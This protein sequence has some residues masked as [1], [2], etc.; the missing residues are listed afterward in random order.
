M[1][2]LLGGLP[3]LNE[4]GRLHTVAKLRMLVRRENESALQ[5]AFLAEPAQPV[6]AVLMDALLVGTTT[7]RDLALA[8]LSDDREPAAVRAAA[9]RSDAQASASP[10][11]SPSCVPH[12]RTQTPMSSPGR[13]EG[14]R[15]ACPCRRHHCSRALSTTAESPEVAR[16]SEALSPGRSR[17][18]SDR[19]ASI[20]QPVLINSRH[21]SEILSSYNICRD[22][23][24]LASCIA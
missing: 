10:R 15:C 17:R 20:A 2:P 12:S 11:S 19:P 24:Q 21:C 3:G 14:W 8:V 5:A 23:E 16:Q 9:A 22:P 6:R 18:C 7:T 1:T 13:L 4:R